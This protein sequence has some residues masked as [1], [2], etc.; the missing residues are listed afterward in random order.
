MAAALCSPALAESNIFL[1]YKE[2]TEAVG[3]TGLVATAFPSALTPIGDILLEVT[4]GPHGIYKVD[5]ARTAVDSHETPHLLAFMRV[6]SFGRRSLAAEAR[7]SRRNFREQT[8]TVRGRRAL[9]MTG[10][11]TGTLVLIWS[12]AGRLYYVQSYT[13]STIRVGD[14]R[15]VAAS[16]GHVLGVLQATAASRQAEGGATANAVV[17]EHALIISVTWNASCATGSPIPLM[18]APDASATLPLTGGA[19]S[20]AP[21]Q[22][23]RP[24]GPE[25]SEGEPSSWTLALSGSASPT[26]A[27]V[28]MSASGEGPAMRCTS[29]PATLQLGP[30][31]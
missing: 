10:R 21:T 2:V 31:P 20:L 17:S 5:Y 18:L 3:K 6:G 4:A 24:P 1:G 27:T 7:S 19:F 9:L 12:E 14:V 29:P 25:Q 22:F 16:L 15:A 28:T 23:P 30:A 13:P 11:H 26:A 8:T